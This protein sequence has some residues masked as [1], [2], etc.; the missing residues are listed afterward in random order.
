MKFRNNLKNELSGRQIL[1]SLGFNRT[2]TLLLW[3]PHPVHLLC[4]ASLCT[5]PCMITGMM[6]QVRAGGAAQ[7]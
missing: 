5:T 6:G 2:A 4:W 1:G 7:R 3:R